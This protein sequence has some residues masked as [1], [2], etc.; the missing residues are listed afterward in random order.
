MRLR[1]RGEAGGSTTPSTFPQWT[2]CDGAASNEASA[3]T[4]MSAC[5]ND[6][7]RGNGLCDKPV[8][9]TCGKACTAGT[10]RTVMKDSCVKQ[11]HSRHQC[12]Q[13]IPSRC[14]Y[15]ASC[16]CSSRCSTNSYVLC[17]TLIHSHGHCAL[18]STCADAQEY[19]HCV[20]RHAR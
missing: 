15:Q 14:A 10:S 8:L 17:V 6:P 7:Q 18:E 5:E 2:S 20:P 9:P 3:R 1:N 19:K 12:Y 4:S 13:V 11:L 16:L